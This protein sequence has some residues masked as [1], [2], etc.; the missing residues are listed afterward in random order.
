MS[1]INTI[2]ISSPPRTGSMWVFNI[3]REIY[4]CLGFNVKP[5]TIPQNDSEMFDIYKNKA[6]S[7]KNNKIKYILKVH[8]I[9]K[10]NL[11]QSKIITTLRDPRDLCISFKEFMK[12]DFNNSLKAAK[13]VKSFSKIYKN[14]KNDYLFTIKYENIE[15]SSIDLILNIANFLNESLNIKQAEEISKKFS[16]NKV[17]EIINK[18]NEKIK[19]KIKRN[20]KIEKNEVVIISNENIRNFDINTGFQTGHISQRKTGD[21]KN[22]FSEDEK[23]IL[24]NE[25]KSWL[26]EFEYD[27]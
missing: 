2:W 27:L 20:L 16:K 8:K 7:E 10:P 14:F 19:D 25:F 21:W 3:T 23:K 9:L 17:L 22:Y 4:K 24:N 11:S 13:T 1:N 12:S 6:L 5:D 15:N 18:K 26:E